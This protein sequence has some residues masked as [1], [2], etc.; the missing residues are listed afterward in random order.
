M[1]LLI[2]LFLDVEITELVVSRCNIFLTVY[3]FTFLLVAALLQCLG[4]IILDLAD[5]YVGVPAIVE[6]L[7]ILVETTTKS[8]LYLFQQIF[9]FLIHCE[10]KVFKRGFYLFLLSITLQTQLI[11]TLLQYLLFGLLFNQHFVKSTHIMDQV[12]F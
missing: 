1:N 10:D 3:G 7:T 6:F 9:V 4:E 12:L 2:F 11:N 8:I 5:L